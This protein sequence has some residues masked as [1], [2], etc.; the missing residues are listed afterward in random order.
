[1][2][3]AKEQIRQIISENNINSV[4][5]IYTLLKDSFKDILQELME[6]E[7]DAT[8]GYEKNHK[9]DLQTDNKRNGHSTK[10]LKSQYSEF[11][12]DVPR[13]RNGEFEP[14]LI[15][16]YQRDISGIEEKVIPL[17]ARGM[18]TRDIHDQLQD[19]YGIELSAEMVS[20]ITD[21]ILPQVKEWQSREY[22]CAMGSSAI[23]RYYCYIPC[24]ST[25]LQAT[26]CHIFHT[27]YVLSFLICY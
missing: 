16:K 1:M 20:K 19:L 10:N 2:A 6:A 12:I 27:L 3:V 11:Q 14:K 13:D 25:L 26:A 15:P 24:T 5:D 8:L 9:G 18:S 17:Y 22:S 4:A 21:K 23:I 7:L